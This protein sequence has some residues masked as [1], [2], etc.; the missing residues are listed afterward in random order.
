MTKTVGTGIHSHEVPGIA[1]QVVLMRDSNHNGTEVYR[2]NEHE[3]SMYR[4][5]HLDDMRV[6]ESERVVLVRNP[7][8]EEI[9][10]YAYDY[11]VDFDTP[12]GLALIGCCRGDDMSGFG[13]EILWD[14]ELP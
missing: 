5:V 2:V 9:G 3:R 4:F 8:Q 14:S 10:Y 7:D 11:A 1:R 6:T 13:D 12:G